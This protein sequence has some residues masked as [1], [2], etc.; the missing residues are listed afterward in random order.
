M[1]LLLEGKCQFTVSA[2]GA[3]IEAEIVEYLEQ[4]L[5]FKPVTIQGRVMIAAK[6]G[7]SGLPD[8][9]VVLFGRHFIQQ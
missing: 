9:R 8:K 7:E 2:G 4:A 6:E 1:I 5:L 3:V